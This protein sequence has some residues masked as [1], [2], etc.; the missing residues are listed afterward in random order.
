[1]LGD[2]EVGPGTDADALYTGALFFWTTSSTSSTATL[3]LSATIKDTFDRCPAGDITKAKISFFVSTS[4]GSS[5]SPVSNA[6]NLPV[7]L[8]NPNEP[9]VGTASA[10]SQ[11]NIGSNQ[12]ITLLIRVAV[13]GYYS[14]NTPVYDVPVT[15]GKAGSSTSLMGGGK[16]VNDGSPFSANGYL[17]LNSVNSCFGSQ[18]LYNKK[19][20]NPQGQVTVTIKSYNR[21]DGTVDTNLHTY[22][23]KSNS[24]SELS[25]ISGSASFGSKTNVSEILENGSKVGLDGGNTMQLIFTPQNQTAPPGSFVATSGVIESSGKC[26]AL[27]GCASIVIF[28]SAGGVWY[29]SSWGQSSGTAPRTYLKRIVKGMV[30]VGV[31]SPATPTISAAT[32]ATVAAPSTAARAY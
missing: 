12:S 18:V 19:G 1:M 6:Q 32:G 7:G 8:V 16:L 11:Y 3:T 13:G 14:L 17:G 5:F 20:I 23:I 27:N 15:I 30:S 28:R 25:L 24:I 29:S 4:G 10:I 21:P 31:S 26:T 2:P 22:F 9:N